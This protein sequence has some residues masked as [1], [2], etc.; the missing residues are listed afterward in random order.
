MRLLRLTQ[1]VVGFLGLALAS[2]SNS[3]GDSP[4][5][6]DAASPDGGVRTDG[7]NRVGHEASAGVQPDGSTT[8]SRDANG[9]HDANAAH[10]AT[11]THDGSATHDAATTHDGGNVVDAS[12]GHDVSSEP[13]DAG[14]DSW[15][16]CTS[17]ADC[18]G[19]RCVASACVAPTCTDGVKD[20]TETDIDCGGAAC[21][22]C[23]IAKSCVASTDCVSKGC[24]YTKHCIAS[25]SCT[26]HH[27]GDTCGA[28]EDTDLG[29][30]AV[31][32]TDEESCCTSVAI[33]GTTFTVDKYLITAGRI[34]AWVTQLAGNLRSF[35][36]TI[37]ASNTNWNPAWNQYIPSTVSEV[38]L[39][40]GP[41]PAPL[42]PSPYPPSD[43]TLNTAGEPTGNWLGQWRDGCSMGK[44]GSPDGARTWW[45]DYAIGS[46][47]A[48][49]AYPQDF[50]DDKAINCIDAYMLTA[51]CIWDGGHLATGAELAAAWGA[52]PFPWSGTAPGVLINQTTQEPSG[53]DSHGLNA[54]SYVAHE[55]GL[56]PAEFVAPYTYNYDPYNLDADNTIHIPAPGRFPLGAGPYGHMDLAGASYTAT[57]IQAGTNSTQPPPAPTVVTQVDHTGTLEGGSWEIHPVISG[58]GTGVDYDPWMPAY[59]AYWAMTGR[60]GR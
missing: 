19:G 3:P 60:C 43:T 4:A 10:D 29:A 49:I 15:H 42:T 56:S 8:T 1:P 45:T 55:F 24:D 25:P 9:A 34:R 51:F 2:C 59:W 48:P 58:T 32:A 38:D 6:T 18:D 30:G 36:E 33:P 11:A 52:G 35:T 27:G 39:Q 14:I 22:P 54:S 20:G 23:A 26:Q 7:G 40:L 28:G 13:H 17:A 5:T 53:T 31:P 41:Y 37:P 50:L 21:A 12:S 46:D 57:A 44:T 47:E 16:G